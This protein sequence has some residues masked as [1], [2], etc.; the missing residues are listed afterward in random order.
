VF[1]I[2]INISLAVIVTGDGAML[3]SLTGTSGVS[4][5]KAD[6]FSSTKN[7]DMAH[8]LHV[9]PVPPNENVATV[10]RRL[11]PSQNAKRYAGQI[12]VLGY[13]HTSFVP[14]INGDEADFMTSVSTSW[15]LIR[16]PL[17]V[18]HFDKLHDPEQHAEKENP[19]VVQEIAEHR[20]QGDDERHL[21]G[22]RRSEDAV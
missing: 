2:R 8:L 1:V 3:Q 6:L 17:V 19:G 16:L 11:H 20:Q 12:G 10:L 14:G 22:G 18:K 15:R 21:V 7:S 4:E 13:D 5:D 9:V